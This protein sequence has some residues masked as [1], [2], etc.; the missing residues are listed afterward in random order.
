MPLAIRHIINFECGFTT[1]RVVLKA[2]LIAIGIGLH[3]QL[4]Q[5]IVGV[6][7]VAPVTVFDA[8][9]TTRQ[10]VVVVVYQGGALT[11]I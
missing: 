1:K 6:L 7:P 8:G 9:F 2:Q 11:P 5:R 4:T 10:V 3:K